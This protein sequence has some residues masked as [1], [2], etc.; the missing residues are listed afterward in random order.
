M[1]PKMLRLL[2]TSLGLTQNALAEKAGVIPR[3]VRRWEQANGEFPVPG[4]VADWLT[5]QW[6][7]YADKVNDA[8]EQGR[9]GSAV[10]IRV[11]TD[12][13]ECITET[14]LSLSEYDAL[15]GHVVM[16]LT[17]RGMAY[18]LHER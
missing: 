5:R 13:V 6:G 2:R 14:G 3:T 17:C 12:E 4:E 15:I 11:Y 9:E 7:L 16:A 10:E 18:S 8:L 1:T